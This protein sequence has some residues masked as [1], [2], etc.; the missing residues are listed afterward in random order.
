MIQSM[1]VYTIKMPM[2]RAFVHA[3]KARHESDSILVCVNVDGVTGYGEAAPRPYVTGETAETVLKALASCALNE[4]DALIDWCSLQGVVAS[5]QALAL[6][7]MLSIDGRLAPAAACALEMALLDVACRLHGRPMVSALHAAGL[8]E[9]MLRPTPCAVSAALVVDLSISPEEMVAQELALA[10]GVKHVKLKVGPD[11]HHAVERV[12]RFRDLIIPSISIS[13]DANAAWTLP[14]AITA[15]RH[16]RGLGVAWIEEPLRPRDWAGLRQLRDETGIAL[17]LDESFVE[18]SDL[19]AAIDQRA[20]DLVNIRVSKCGGPLRAA[21]LA[22]TA[23]HSGLGYQIGVQVGEHGPLWAAGRSLATSLRHASACEVGR[24]DQWFPHDTTIPPFPI[25]RKT[26]LAPPLSGH[27][28][29]V[30]PGP[31][32]WAH[33]RHAFSYV[34]AT[35]RSA[36][37]EAERRVTTW[38]AEAWG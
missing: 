3:T 9:D 34:A 10:N 6:P 1:D 16:L 7:E 2:H 24:A 26:Y 8:G 38:N 29:G 18:E 35:P 23:F 22:D 25:D 12:K 15:C 32:L 28:H 37:V 17:M 11:G 13:V 4:L 30:V 5:L 21:G 36:L 19:A 14:Q 27:G 20:C 31:A 33:A